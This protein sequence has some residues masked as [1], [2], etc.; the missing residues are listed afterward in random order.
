M[1][2]TSDKG[3]APVWLRADRGVAQSPSGLSA[4]P[5]AGSYTL[6]AVTGGST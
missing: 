2:Y 3:P 1:C 5:R 4:P 6:P